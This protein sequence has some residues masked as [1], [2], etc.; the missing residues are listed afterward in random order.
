MHDAVKGRTAEDK[1]I[2]IQEE[3]ERMFKGLMNRCMSEHS[4]VKKKSWLRDEISLDHLLP[5]FGNHI[6]PEVTPDLIWKYK[7]LRLN[8]FAKR[9]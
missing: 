5:F 7:C 6:V 8:G 9:P 3:S 1:W 4:E 2:G